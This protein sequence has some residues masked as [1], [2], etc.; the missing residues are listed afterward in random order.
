MKKI[1]F[2]LSAAGLFAATGCETTGDPTQGGL[3]GWSQSKANQRL[4]DRR[5]ILGAVEDDTAREASRTGYLEDGVYI[6]ERELDRV[7]GY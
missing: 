5:A 1:L 6:R 3:F 7:R 4:D 2:I